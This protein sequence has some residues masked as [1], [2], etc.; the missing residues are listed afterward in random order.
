M[1]I[2]GKDL[3]RM[4]KRGVTRE[5]LTK[6]TTERYNPKQAVK[7]AVE[8]LYFTDVEKAELKEFVKGL[9][10]KSQDAKAPGGRRISK[11][12]STS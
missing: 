3:T 8:T 2:E 11:E 12:K 10:N 1:K 5:D 7:E 9:G 4:A 6:F